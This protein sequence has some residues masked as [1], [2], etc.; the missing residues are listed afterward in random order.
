MLYTRANDQ[1]IHLSRNL[2]NDL[3]RNVCWDSRF[4]I[5]V[6]LF[7]EGMAHPRAESIGSRGKHLQGNSILAHFLWHWSDASS[8]NNTIL[9]LKLQV[10]ATKQNCF[11]F[12]R[13][14]VS[15]LF[16][17]LTLGDTTQTSQ[18][19]GQLISLDLSTSPQTRRWQFPL[20][21]QMSWPPMWSSGQSSWLQKG[22]VC[23]S[24]EVRTEFIYSYVMYKRVDRLC[25]L[26]VRVPGYRTEMYVFPA[27]Y[28][29]N[30]YML[31]RRK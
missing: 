25:G 4:A 15:G 7:V 5:T 14:A 2:E 24:C 9:L 29:L 18:Q 16:Y 1:K 30:L 11:P 31:C 20:L 23:V 19:G 3:K 22:D 26:V 13:A 12:H 27:R 21:I 8:T 6:Y 28:E 17:G 10:S